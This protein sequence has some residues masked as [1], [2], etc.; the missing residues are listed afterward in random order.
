MKNINKAALP[1]ALASVLFSSHASAIDYDKLHQQLDIMSDIIKSSVKKQSDNKGPQLARIES[2]YLAGQG[3]VFN[4][5]VARVLYYGHNS[6]INTPVMPLMPVVPRPP[7]NSEGHEGA[8]L[9]GE[10][11]EIVIEEAMEEAAIAIEMINENIRFDAEDQ[12]E[13]REQ[14]RELAYELRDLAREERDLNYEKLHLDDDEKAEYQKELVEIKKRKEV[15]EQAKVK[16]KKRAKEYKAKVQKVQD[17]KA[18]QQQLF[19]SQLESNITDVLC[20]YGG[21]LKE[22]PDSEYISMIINGAGNTIDGRTKDKVLV[23]NKLDVK[24]CVLER[25]DAAALLSK[26]NGYQ[27]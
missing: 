11:Y 9:F 24:N 27:F 19:Y 14:E 22:L 21:G 25:I 17:E 8:E 23:F 18:K 7:R 6:N 13:L 5:N 4:L 1:L 2:H 16:V 20:S 10:N 15:I 3:V 12:R 26:A